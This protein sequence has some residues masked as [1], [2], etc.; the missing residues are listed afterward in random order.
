M[1]QPGHGCDA[2][3]KT[4]GWFSVAC[5]GRSC[6][7]CP[8]DPWY[9]VCHKWSRSVSQAN[10]LS[11]DASLRVLLQTLSLFICKEVCARKSQH[12][13]V[14]ALELARDI[15]ANAYPPSHEIIAPCANLMAALSA[16]TESED[17]VGRLSCLRILKD[18]VLPWLTDSD[19][20]TDDESHNELVRHPSR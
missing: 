17:N 8:K 20:R 1:D 19:G 18:G 7:F 10:I 15:L 6:D 3:G 16:Y 14:K 9:R 11:R 2:N 5:A 4:Q 13:P 12:Q